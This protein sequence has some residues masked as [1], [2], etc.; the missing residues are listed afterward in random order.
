MNKESLKINQEDLL[1]A[2][3]AGGINVAPGALVQGGALQSRDLSE[4]MQIATF[5]DS[6]IKMQKLLDVT[7]HKSTLVEFTRQ[8]DYGQIGGS[9]TFEGQ[10]GADETSTYNKYVVPMAYYAHTRRYTLPSELVNT[11]DGMKPESRVE[12][13]AAMKLAGDIEFHIFRGKADYS[14]AGAFDGNPLAGNPYE[15]G[16]EG[17]DVQVRQSDFNEEA[18]DLYLSEYGGDVSVV[19]DQEGSTLTQ[20]VVEDIF[21]RAQLTNGDI[22]SL[23][24]D[25][26][27]HAGYNKISHVKERIVLAGSPQSATG[28][29]L[30]EQF[31]AD[32]VI[33]V[34]SNRFLAAKTSVPARSRAGAPA[35]P[36]FVAAQAGST[37]S[38]L[39]PEVYQYAVSAANDVGESQLSAVTGVTIA[40][41]GNQVNLTITPVASADVK[42]FNVYRSLAGETRVYFIGRV[43]NSRAATTV[44]N[45]LNAKR[46]NATTGF[47]VTNMSMHLKELAPFSSKDL[48]ITDLSTPKV[49]YRFVQLAVPLPRFNFLVDN[50]TG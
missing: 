13:D 49:F 12:K 43:A 9:A 1:K 36:S 3:E 6:K 27:A 20:D 7:P 21:S 19:F 10:T 24:L 50:I 41:N 48:A 15:A 42:W 14:N 31:V 23:H 32:G 45:D 28:A 5:N 39:A 4:V 29:S 16:I 44:F 38:F 17:I 2:L 46:P 33:K 18:T 47:A 40:V 8:L 22:D 34:S 25:P 26:I 35:A 37:T 30:R 11:F